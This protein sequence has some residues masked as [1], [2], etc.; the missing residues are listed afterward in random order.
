M[1]DWTSKDVNLDVAESRGIKE[2]HQ[3]TM[4]SNGKDTHILENQNLFLKSER[5][6]VGTVALATDCWKI[7][8]HCHLHTSCMYNTRM[9][10]STYAK[11]KPNG[12]WFLRKFPKAVTAC[13]LGRRCSFHA[14]WKWS[15]HQLNINPIWWC[16][17][18][19]YSCF[20]VSCSKMISPCIITPCIPQWFPDGQLRLQS[21][22]LDFKHVPHSSKPTSSSGESCEQKGLQQQVLP[23]SRSDAL[24]LAW[25][26]ICRKSAPN[27]QLQTVD[28]DFGHPQILKNENIK[29]SWRYWHATI[30]YIQFN[31]QIFW[32]C[33]CRGKVWLLLVGIHKLA[34]HSSSLSCSSSI[35][36]G[37]GD[38]WQ[39]PCA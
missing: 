37:R 36:S 26:V 11:P 22:C 32:Y 30:I 15:S 2:N 5:L 18:H 25:L 20:W 34:N 14:W 3:Q 19:R 35:S 12:P 29:T 7:S 24:G 31:P 27:L 23:P 28:T 21:L 13:D 6:L 16:M 8:N 38:K 9:P 10:V 1:K 39:E 17:L 33:F 4:W